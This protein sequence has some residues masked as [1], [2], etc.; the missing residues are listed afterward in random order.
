MNRQRPARCLAVVFGLLTAAGSG[1][2]PAADVTLLTVG[3]TECRF[4]FSGGA[5]P[6]VVRLWEARRQRGDTVEVWGRGL[7]LRGPWWENPYFSN[8]WYING[9][10]DV[11][12]NGKRVIHNPQA[13]KT[14]P[15]FDRCEVLESGARAL[16]QLVWQRDVG[17]VRARFLLRPD[18]RALL[19]E[20]VVQPQQPL[21][22]FAVTGA[23]FP[24]A[25]TKKADGDRRVR[26]ARREG[27]SD[28]ELRIDPRHENWMCF[29]DP[30]LDKAKPIQR[31]VGFHANGCAG[32]YVLADGVAGVDVKLTGYPITVSVRAKPGVTRLR[33]AYDELPMPNVEAIKT[34]RDTAPVVER[35][36]KAET[37]QPSSLTGFAAAHQRQCIG[38]LPGDA[39]RPALTRA[40]DR[41]EQ[42]VRAFRS[43]TTQPVTREQKALSTLHV[44]RRGLLTAQRHASNTVAVFEMRGPGYSRYRTAEAVKQLGPGVGS[45]TGG[46]LFI[47]GQGRTLTPC[48]GTADE[49]Y[50]YDVV[51]MLDVDTRALSAPFLNLLRQYVEDGGGLAV[52]GG[53]Y[54]YG[55][56]HIKDTPLA[57]IL[58]LRVAGGAFGLRKA[59]DRRLRRVRPAAFLADVKWHNALVSPWY[60][61]LTPAKDAQV[62]VANGKAPWWAV[63]TAGNGRVAACAGTLLGEPAQGRTMFYRW[64]R[65]PDV[66]AKMVRWLAGK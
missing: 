52:F 13:F 15:L 36:L 11:E 37:F 24:G 27:A 64:E 29:Y 61:E 14:R 4:A 10:L 48:P 17:V 3:D 43:A 57:D 20:V 26:T 45:V 58:P 41:A 30:T 56:S 21:R 34:V 5:Y 1:G 59:G 66:L 54:S 9:F 35:L 2:A 47:G 25:Y 19:A 33:L 51:V 8:A 22:S 53:L 63:C 62:L 65:W 39:R 60:H 40:L 18:C 6:Y 31:P 55:A 49:L 7:G 28:A 23:C 38:E 44:Y 12:V 42:A 16:V 32:L 50:R 46:Y